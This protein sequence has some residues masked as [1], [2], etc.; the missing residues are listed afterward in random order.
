VVRFFVYV[1]AL[2][3]CVRTSYVVV[4]V[5]LRFGVLLKLCCRKS[6]LLTKYVLRHGRRKCVAYN[7]LR[8]GPIMVAMIALLILINMQ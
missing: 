5:S 2:C 3:S 7:V 1:L 8:H 6:L 4:L